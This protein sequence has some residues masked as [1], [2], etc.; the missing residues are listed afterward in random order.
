[1]NDIQ[2]V[3]YDQFVA[4]LAKPGQ[5]IVDS[6]TAEK[7]HMLHMA[8]GIAGEAGELLSAIV[9]N[10]HFG[11]EL[12]RTNMIEELGDVEFYAEGLIQA[13]GVTPAIFK[14]PVRLTRREVHGAILSVI[15]ADLLDLVKKHVIYDKPLDK[16]A[17]CAKLV[18][19][20]HEMTCL[21]TTI[22]VTREEVIAANKEKLGKRY[23]SG[24]Y[25]DKQAQERADK[26]AGQ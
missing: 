19:L 11:T 26:A 20:V 10:A 1:M 15:A 9:D 7:A 17:V 16:A 23:S 2:S 21:R 3:P 4:S 12:D 6:M 18:G 13:T 8:V 22:S 25:T 5:A 14:A 24:S